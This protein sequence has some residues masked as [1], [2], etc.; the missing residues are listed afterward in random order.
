[1]PTRA[2]YVEIDG[3]YFPHHRKKA[4]DEHGGCKCIQVSRECV[5]GKFTEPCATCG[6]VVALDEDDICGP[7]YVRREFGGGRNQSRL[8]RGGRIKGWL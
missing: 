7:C 3:R 4:N 5:C 6:R 8:Q 2:G 1:M